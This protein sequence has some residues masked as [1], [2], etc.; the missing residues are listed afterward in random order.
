MQG[1]KVYHKSLGRLKLWLSWAIYEP[2]YS[3]VEDKTEVTHNFLCALSYFNAE[4]MTFI[5]F[6]VG[7]AQITVGF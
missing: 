3:I 7:P 2:F 6:Q 4:K 5:S 1:K